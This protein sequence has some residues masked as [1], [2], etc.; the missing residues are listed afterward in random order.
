MASHLDLLYTWMKHL[1]QPQLTIKVFTLHQRGFFS[2]KI[3]KISQNA[4]KKLINISVV[5]K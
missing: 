2:Y 5:F 1:E 4:Y 3:H